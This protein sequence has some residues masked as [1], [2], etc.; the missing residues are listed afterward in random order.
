MDFILADPIVIPPD[1]DQWYSERVVRLPHCYLPNDDQREIGPRP[2]RQ[3]VGLPTTG[4]VFCAFTNAYKITPPIFGV[5]MQLLRDVPGSVLW[6]RDMGIDARANLE[7]EAATRGVGADR[8]VFAPHVAAM[9]EHLGRHALAD[10]YLDTLPYN[11]HST[12]CDALW[13]GVPVLTCA[14]RSMAA[15]VAASALTA[16]GL[17][18]LITRSLDEYGRVAHE[19]ATHPDR[20]RALREKIKNARQ[21]AALF[22]TAQ[23]TRDLER[24]FENMRERSEDG[25]AGP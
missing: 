17:P 25:G 6:L 23:Y 11:A 24:A 12:V 5:W 14:G 9:S 4:F 15:R 22:A 19:L 20:L 1:E 8:L 10:L 16:M 18:E 3:S 2:P 7:R 21:S 13:S